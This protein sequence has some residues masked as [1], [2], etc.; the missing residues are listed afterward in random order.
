MLDP[1][2]IYARLSLWTAAFVAY[3]SIVLRVARPENEAA[4]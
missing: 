3:S 1:D 2:R 4:A